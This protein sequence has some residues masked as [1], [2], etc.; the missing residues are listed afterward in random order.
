MKQATG[1]FRGTGIRELRLALYV[2][3]AGGLVTTLILYG[4]HAL[5]TGISGN[6]LS[7][8][9]TY[10]YWLTTFFG[11]LSGNY[12]G[13][14]ATL[15]LAAVW[16]ISVFLSGGVYALLLEGEGIS[17]RRLFSLSAK[18]FP[19][20]IRVFLANILN[21]LAASAIPGTLFYIHY[22]KQSLT[23]DE[24]LLFFFIYGWGA[25]TALIFVYS[26]AVYDLSRLFALKEEQGGFR[27]LKSGIK[28]VARRKGR[29]LRIFT[30]YIG[31][32]VLLSLCY[33]GI[34]GHWKNASPAVLIIILQQLFLFLRYWMKI[35]L[36]RSE[37]ALIPA[38]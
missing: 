7:A 30:I 25:L 2:W 21:F 33:A 34:A 4:F 35:L 6:P 29:V 23:P 16:L 17:V 13:G 11:D 15:A 20:M 14:M 31:A 37:A 32:A 18:N 3:A 27:S 36:M 12:P 24:S 8:R 38:D 26:F 1:F 5:F 28:T 9:G 10:Y 22:K 19:R